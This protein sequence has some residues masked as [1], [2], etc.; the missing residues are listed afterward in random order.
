MT[1][2]T[3]KDI[4]EYILDNLPKD[5][6]GKLKLPDYMFS[7]DVV[8]AW[9]AKSL[10]LVERGEKAVDAKEAFFDIVIRTPNARFYQMYGGN[11]LPLYM[12]A[13]AAKDNNVILFL[14]KTM[15]FINHRCKNDDFETYRKHL[16]KLQ[17]D[18]T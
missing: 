7:C 15:A 3:I 17:N 10:L 4:E 5:D 9:M 11:L 16:E 6:K 12:E 18:T 2:R 1:L 13:L 8:I 14:T